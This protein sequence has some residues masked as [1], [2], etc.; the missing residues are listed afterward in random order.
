[1]PLPHWRQFLKTAKRTWH[2]RSEAKAKRSLP[3]KNWRL[4][5]VD[6]SEKGPC[7]RSQERFEGVIGGI[8]GLDE[9]AEEDEGGSGVEEGVVPGFFGD[10]GADLVA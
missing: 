10:E 6:L 3:E 8:E 4:M 7:L 2:G 9:V 5:R 1:M